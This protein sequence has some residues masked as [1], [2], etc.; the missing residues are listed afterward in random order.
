MRN[1]GRLAL[2]GLRRAERD[3]RVA[4]ARRCIK[5]VP[6]NVEAHAFDVDEYTLRQQ[7]ADESE[8]APAAREAQARL[9]KVMRHMIIRRR[10]ARSTPGACA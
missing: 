6:Q 4:D 8:P 10:S 9:E 7:M 3:A 5:F 1:A 2:G